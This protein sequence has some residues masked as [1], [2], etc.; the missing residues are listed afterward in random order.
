VNRRKKAQ[1]T[2][3]LGVCDH[4]QNMIDTNYEFLKWTNDKQQLAPFLNDLLFDRYAQRKRRTEALA[5]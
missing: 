3:D 5:K 1:L 2:F 4:V